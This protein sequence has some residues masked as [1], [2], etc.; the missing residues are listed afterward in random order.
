MKKIEAT[1]DK[2]SLPEVKRALKA[3]GITGL[4]VYE[5][6]SE[7]QHGGVTL[8]W[9]GTPYQMDMLPKMQVDIYLDDD[10]VERAI[11]IIAWAA[12]ADG[13]RDGVIL[14]LPVEDVVRIRSGEH[15]LETL[16]HNSDNQRL[17]AKGEARV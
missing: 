15:G 5:I 1:I 8:S 16:A 11:D 3:I 2:E 7:D 6:H 13:E 12:R 4:S 10:D 14:V 9:R 17:T